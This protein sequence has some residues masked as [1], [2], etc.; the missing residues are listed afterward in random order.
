MPTPRICIIGSINVDF[1][2]YTSRYPE[3]GETLLASAHEISGGG[4]GAN[5]AVACGR[6]AF[7]SK[8]EHEQDRAGVNTTAVTER[9][10]APTGSASIAVEGAAGGEN[11]ILVVPGANYAGMSDVD[12]ILARARREMAGLSFTGGHEVVVLQGEIPRRTVLGLLR[13]FNGSRKHNDTRAHVVLNP[14]PVFAEGIPVDALRGMS[15]L[16]MNETEARMMAQFMGVLDSL[17]PEELAT[18]FHRDVDVQI[19]LITLGSRGVFYSTKTSAAGFVAGVSVEKVVDTSGAGDTFVGYFAVSLARFL[20]TGMPLAS[21]DTHIE[22]S[23]RWSNL[24]AGRSVEKKGAM[25]GI[26]FAY[27]L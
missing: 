1:T 23:V 2:T 24:A 9:S 8:T 13:Y 14:A 10:D 12:E 16:I 6:A 4:K 20:A 5:Q 21:F 3:P 17:E 25:N 7:A 19:V 15:V 27:E 18:R 11:R 26:P 22:E